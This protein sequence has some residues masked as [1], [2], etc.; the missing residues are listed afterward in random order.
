MEYFEKFYI[1]NKGQH[2]LSKKFQSE[3]MS[4]TAKATSKE[5]GLVITP[6]NYHHRPKRKIVWDESPLPN[7]KTEEKERIH[8]HV[9]L[10]QQGR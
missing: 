10:I 1:L 3:W 2:K 4:V 9:K 8:A 5:V 7:M 6:K